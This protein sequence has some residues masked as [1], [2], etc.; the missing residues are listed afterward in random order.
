MQRCNILDA[1][2]SEHKGLLNK[3]TSNTYIAMNNMLTICSGVDLK[4][5]IA[6]VTSR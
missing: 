2:E 5:H 1:I 4:R 3:Y 6:H